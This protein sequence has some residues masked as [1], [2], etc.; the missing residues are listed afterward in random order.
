MDWSK[1]NF[2][3]T[4]F[5]DGA[6]NAIG[7]FGVDGSTAYY[8]LPPNTGPTGIA[9]D[10]EGNLWVTDKLS[11]QVT[12]LTIA[13]AAPNTDSGEHTFNLS[14]TSPDGISVDPYGNV[15]VGEGDS[16]ILG[17][18][19]GGTTLQEWYV[20][21][22]LEGMLADP[23]G[24]V[25]AIIE[26]GTNAGVDHIVPSQLP[27]PT[28][29]SLVTTGVYPV[30]GGAI[31]GGTEQ[32]AV[33]PN[34]DIWFTQWGPPELGV[35]VPSSTN[36]A[37]DQWAYAANYPSTGFAPS[38]IGVDAGGN[39]WITDAGG[40]S[41][42]KFAPGTINPTSPIPG[43]WTSYAVG[44]WVTNYPEGDEGN[45]L[46][47]S[48]AGDVLFSGYVTNGSTSYAPYT[49]P[50]V[51]GYIAELPGVATPAS[52]TGGT[53]TGGTT[54]TTVTIGSGGNTVVIPSGTVI[55][56]TGGSPFTG[57][58]PP[59]VPSPSFVPPAIFGSLI[60]GSA[61]SV[62]P[63]LLDGVQ[64][65]LTFS[66]PVTV[67]FAFALPSGVTAAQVEAATLWTY[68][69]ASNVWSEAGS[70]AGDPGG[71]TVVSG[72]QVTITLKTMHLSSFALLMPAPATPVITSL[73]STSITPGSNVI[74]NG[75]NL[76]ST[77]G[78]AT[79]S[80]AG[81]TS[82]SPV[83]LVVTT[84]SATA[85][86]VT[87]PLTQPVGSYTL[88][89]TTAAALTTNGLPLAV[90]ILPAFTSAPMDSVASGTAFSFKVTTTGTPTP[91]I[92][93]ATGS[94]LPSAVTLTDNHDGTATL[95]GTSGVAAGV[96]DFTMQASNGAGKHHSG[97][98]SYR[99]QGSS[100][101]EC[102][103]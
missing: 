69:A 61:F 68:D 40:H 102:L 100:H 10:Q 3:N 35:I 26:D 22:D 93:L 90:S 94:T 44:A 54:S 82:G 13:A 95:A 87:V 49:D 91:A 36:P 45:N 18:I 81:L 17:E 48:P 60:P 52:S 1:T 97:L 65:H 30:G 85:A 33:A 80:P 27:A 84:W 64:T 28:T 67:T 5:A 89:L 78:T 71:T 9:I 37:A 74:V 70:D 19:V 77:T 14:G 51:H 66:Q 6:R 41:I 23:F 62:S 83:P 38:G 79:L 8:P 55:T 98:H 34:G 96:Y 25:W 56:A 63:E 99:D 86:T 43:V 50:D 11:G 20:G 75:A 53:I 31:G 32:L 21:G 29:A 57:T 42:F 24:N 47:V 73:S 2:G 39:L 101:H 46:H 16:G 4:W 72:S 92:T 88:T 15:W 76:G 7:E 58:I 12:E 103:D 59:P